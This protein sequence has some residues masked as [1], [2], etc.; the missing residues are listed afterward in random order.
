MCVAAFDQD[1]R[2]GPQRIAMAVDDRSA[3]AFDDA[4]P[5]I[6]ASMRV[7]WSAFGFSRLEDHF[8]GLRAGI[9]DGKPEAVADV[10]LG[11]WSILSGRDKPALQRLSARASSGSPSCARLSMMR[12]RRR[13]L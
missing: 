2:A 13:W 6:A 8:R 4:Q 3:L 1:E 9:A 10:K 12:V 7:V 11:S 5:L